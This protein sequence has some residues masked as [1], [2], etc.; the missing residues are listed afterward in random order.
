MAEGGESLWRDNDAI[1]AMT[2]QQLLEY[3]CERGGGRWRCVR[4]DRPS[5][6]ARTARTADLARFPA[7]IGRVPVMGPYSLAESTLRGRRRALA[8]TAPASAPVLTPTCLVSLHREAL[9]EGIRKMR[10]AIDAASPEGEQGAGDGGAAQPDQPAAS[11]DLKALQRELDDLNKEES[12]LKDELAETDAA[13]E[14]A[15]GENGAMSGRHRHGL[16]GAAPARFNP[17]R[18]AILRRAREYRRCTGA[19]LPCGRGGGAPRRD[20]A[21]GAR[22][23]GATPCAGVISRLGCVPRVSRGQGCAGGGGSR[24]AHQVGGGGGSPLSSPGLSHGGSHRRARHQQRG[25]PPLHH[26]RCVSPPF[27]WTPAP[28]PPLPPAAARSCCTSG[29]ASQQRCAARGRC[30]PSPT[31]LTADAV[32]A[33]RPVASGPHRAVPAAQRRAAEGGR[34]DGAG[35]PGNEGLPVRPL[36]SCA[37]A[38]ARAP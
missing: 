20:F 32:P 9:G 11:S 8:E 30:R 23:G 22:G 29:S 15:E 16:R 36:A 2:E 31:A 21:A 38:V 10:Q 33:R 7:A 6:S 25:T 14:A 17:R 35:G 37:P 18:A 27:P 34:G 26:P 12:R 24:A 28:R 3:R 1:E 4:S 5:C 19:R 13:V